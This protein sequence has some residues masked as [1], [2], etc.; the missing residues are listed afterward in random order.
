MIVPNDAVENLTTAITV[1]LRDHMNINTYIDFEII[2][3]IS[4]K[5]VYM[6]HI[7]ET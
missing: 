6:L 1:Y 2:K 4:Y 5:W 3:N 7:K